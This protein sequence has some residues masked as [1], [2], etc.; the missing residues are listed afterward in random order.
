MFISSLSSAVRAIL[1]IGT[2]SH[3]PARGAHTRAESATADGISM[4]SGVFNHDERKVRLLLM[5]IAHSAS[6]VW[7]PLQLMR[8]FGALA[9]T[10]S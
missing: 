9:E 5:C 7:S 6:H 8:I 3:S 10:A 4:L 2:P 1:P